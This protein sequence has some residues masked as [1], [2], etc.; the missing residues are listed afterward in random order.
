MRRPN[1]F[2]LPPAACTAAVEGREFLAATTGFVWV[3]CD[4]VPSFGSYRGP[5]WRCDLEGPNASPELK[6]WRPR[7]QPCAGTASTST[8][9]CLRGPDDPA[10]NRRTFQARNQNE[11][12]G[13]GCRRRPFE[14]FSRFQATRPKQPATFCASAP[15][16]PQEALSLPRIGERSHD[17][18]CPCRHFGRSFDF[19]DTGTRLCERLGQCPCIVAG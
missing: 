12:T 14:A 13:L 17:P 9:S 18:R 5:P 6:S 4:R 8:S 1:R 16:S 7:R 11:T 3:G 10:P 15:N 19:M 2:F